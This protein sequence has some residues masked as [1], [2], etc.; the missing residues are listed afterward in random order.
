MLRLSS[1]ISLL[2]KFLDRLRAI[3]TTLSPERVIV[4]WISITFSLLFF[5]FA[6]TTYIDKFLVTVPNYGGTLREGI[7]GTP[8]FINPVLAV[9]EQDKDLTALIFAGLTKKDSDGHIVLNMAESV[10]PSEDGL[11]YTVKL[12]DNAYFH[13]GKKVVADDILYTISL[14]KNPVI[15]SP[16]AI[17]WEGVTVE[18]TNDAEMVFSLKKPFPLFMNTL[19]IGIVPKHVWKNLTDEQIS[20]SDYNIKAVGSGPYKITDIQTDSGIPTVFTLTSHKQYTLGRPYLDT[21]I[22]SC[23]QNEK[24]LLKAFDDNDITRVHAISP[25]KAVALS[26]SSSKVSVET[27]LLPRT[28]AVFLNP[29]KNN[30]LSDKHI[31]R[32]LQLA[33][34]KQTIVD[35]V[36]HKYGK[37]VNDPY[38]FDEDT[39]DHIYDLSL[40][41]NE[42]EQSKQLKNGTS[43]LSIVLSTANTEE[44]KTIASMIEHDWEAL[45][46]T[47]SLN[48]YEVSDLNQSVIKDRDFQALLFGTITQNPSDLYAFWH[49]TQRSYPGLNI[50]NYVSKNLDA[51][52][53]TLRES[54]D[55]LTR[56]GAYENLKK[57]FA[58]E[59]PGIFLY[60]PSLIYVTKDS[61]TSPLPRYSID[62]ASRFALVESWYK[63]SDRVWSKL[64][65]KP[66]L[67]LLENILH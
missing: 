65:Y 29:N 64:Y 31:R 41:R 49:S 8:R 23:Y 1:L 22:I 20:L 67:Q 25:E 35:E 3:Y 33:I 16:H 12:K 42:L 4:F 59:V 47:V 58:E 5:F 37:V 32:A 56:L 43:G 38:P 17:E 36:L 46:V 14:I 19:T 13:D 7:V 66:M 30:I 61:I 9:T 10:V 57:E 21:I 24:Y 26:T 45:G 55:E 53:E 34:N 2:K 48:V 44:M 52:L 39:A 54:E 62:N 27:S 28:F 15:K 40:A 18:K 63:Y 60:A 11:T 50:S 51:N 6:I